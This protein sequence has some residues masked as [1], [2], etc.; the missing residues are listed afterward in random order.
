MS[1][2]FG[3]PGDQNGNSTT[4]D[5]IQ[6]ITGAEY[7][8]SGILAGC[9]VSTTSATNPMGYK[10]ADG[11]VIIT[12]STGRKIKVPVAGQTIPTTAAP[13]T[14][15]RTES[16]Y[17]KQN[18][19]GTDGN[20][21]VVVGVGASVPANAVEIDKYTVPAGATSSSQFT[22]VSNT[23]YALPVGGTLGALAGFVDKDNSQHEG[24]VLTRGA[25]SFYVPTDRFVEVSMKSCVSTSVAAANGTTPTDSGSVLYTFY[26]DGKPVH[27]WERG[28]ST[29]W[30]A[31]HNEFGYTLNAGAHTMHYTVER[32]FMPAGGSGKWRVR[33][34][35]GGM[36]PGDVFTI[37]DRGVGVV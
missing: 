15:S 29:L 5:D 24:E 10:V 32:R 28:Y 36:Y 35:Q 31:K 22:R 2:G 25:V 23:K 17:V 34:E 26:V 19:P 18:F 12:L 27:Y 37:T 3:V 33:Y 13:A 7:V 14:G 8:S 4:P 1:T 9:Q 16:V 20:N 21:A 11:A 30:E 6:V